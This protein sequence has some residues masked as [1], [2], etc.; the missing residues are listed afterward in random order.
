MNKLSFLGIGPRIGIV[1][2]PWLALSIY[3]SI[4]F[5]NIFAFTAGDSK[6]LF[7]IGLV[8]LADGAL[9]YFFTAP[10]LLK[11]LKETKLVTSGTYYLCRNPLYAAIIL[12]II[13]GVSL[14]MNSWLVLT[15]SIVAYIVFRI[16]IKRENEELEKFFGD[17]YLKYKSETPE[18]LPFPIKKLFGTK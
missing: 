12:L 18:L 9:M 10:S 13:P 11:G 8:I 14:M 2:I 17:E 5:R 15:T 3:L 16:F 4:K 1:A 7:Y 6:I